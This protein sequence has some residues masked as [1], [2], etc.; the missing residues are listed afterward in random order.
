M[1]KLKLSLL[2]L[3]SLVFGRPA[4]MSTANGA[5]DVAQQ[6]ADDVATLKKQFDDQAAQIAALQE[7]LAAKNAAP[8]AVE[9]NSTLA[10][11]AKG[12]GVELA[13]VVWRKRAGL[14]DDQAVA[15]ASAQKKYDADKKAKAAAAAAAAAK[16]A[17]K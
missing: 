1:K 13:D 9:D 8:A 17:K 7:Q 4:G 10:L 11:L 15:A 3:A 6:A 5:A 2:M 14:D 16:A 12:A